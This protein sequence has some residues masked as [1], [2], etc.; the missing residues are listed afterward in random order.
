MEVTYIDLIPRL[1]LAWSIV[2]RSVRRQSLLT[3]EETVVV[4]MDGLYVVEGEEAVRPEQHGEHN[5]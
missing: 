2:F 4:A 5:H 1:L 3:L